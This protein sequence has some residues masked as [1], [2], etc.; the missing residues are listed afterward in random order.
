[1]EEQRSP[2]GCIARRM[3]PDFHHGLLESREPTVEDHADER[4]PA[5]TRS[6][7]QRHCE[8]GPASDSAWSPGTKADLKVRLYGRRVRLRSMLA[9]LRPGLADME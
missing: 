8:R 2:R 7:A 4:G 5:D 9:G 3:Q 1:M 6:D